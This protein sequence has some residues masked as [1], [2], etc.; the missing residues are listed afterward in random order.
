[1]LTVDPL[2]EGDSGNF[3][4]L[5]THIIRILHSLGAGEV[6]TFDAR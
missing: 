5:V 1:M 2:H 3:K 4:K 6:T